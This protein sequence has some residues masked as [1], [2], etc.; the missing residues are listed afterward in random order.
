MSKKTLIALI[1]G[2]EP[3]LTTK[4]V[5]GLLDLI[6]SQIVKEIKE[7]GKC[8]FLSLGTFNK[9][10]T[11][12]REGYSPQ[13][14]TRMKIPATVSCSFKIGR[15]LRKELDSSYAK[16]IEKRNQKK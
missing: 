10:N 13:T 2:A 4:K 5:E 11:K 7:E 16:R 14:S 12:A 6:E 3:S 9:K 15:R 1:K 8:K